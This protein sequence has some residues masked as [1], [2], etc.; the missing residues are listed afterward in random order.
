MS[1]IDN[2][3]NTIT[4]QNK[5]ENNKESLG[6]RFLK[7]VISCSLLSG[8]AGALLMRA[9]PSRD[10]QDTIQANK[11]I[12]DQN[13]QDKQK[14]IQLENEK[15]CEAD[16]GREYETVDTVRKKLDKYVQQIQE[17]HRKWGEHGRDISVFDENERNQISQIFNDLNFIRDE[18]KGSKEG[19]ALKD[20]MEMYLTTFY[21]GVVETGA[22]FSSE[23]YCIVTLA[24]ISSREEIPTPNAGRLK[25]LEDKRDAYMDYYVKFIR[26]E[27]QNCVNRK[28]ENK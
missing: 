16:V 17:M 14:E 20:A 7:L 21:P 10:N 9:C 6:H 27:V 25:D 1:D 18:S 23:N 3:R 5:D 13:H 15:G 11:E 24:N 12:A 19:Q 22:L 2:Q 4:E 28:K 8:L 26:E